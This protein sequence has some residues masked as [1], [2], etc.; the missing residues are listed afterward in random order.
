MRCLTFAR[1]NSEAGRVSAS[2]GL[3]HR[4]ASSAGSDFNAISVPQ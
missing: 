4:L 3:E 1:A 2:E